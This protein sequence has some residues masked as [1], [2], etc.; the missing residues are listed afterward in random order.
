MVCGRIY[1]SIV[2]ESVGKSLVGHIFKDSSR[3]EEGVD[4]HRPDFRPGSMFMKDAWASFG[5]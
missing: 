1:S 3:L 4:A 2:K 5:L